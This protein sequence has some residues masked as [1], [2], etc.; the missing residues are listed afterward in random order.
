[1]RFTY[2][3]V[4]IMVGG[5]LAGCQPATEEAPEPEAPA[6]TAM[7]DEDMLSAQTD[8]FAAAWAEG[9][10][11]GLAALFI[12]EGDTVGPDG[13]RFHGR[14]AVQGRYQELLGGMYQGTTVSISQTSTSFPSPDVAVVNGT[15][16]IMGMKTGDGEDME[17]K[18]LYMNVAVKQGGEW[19]IHC[20]RP[21]L[22]LPMPGT[23]T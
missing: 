10:A 1:M 4:V 22:P 20:A 8:A 11:A 13:V 12:E 23:G 18:G 15:Y 9:D 19:K 21:M 3:F 14:E 2:L 7:S 16:E 5:L 6:E 17:I